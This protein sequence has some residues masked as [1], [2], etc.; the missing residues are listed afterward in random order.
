MSLKR[1]GKAF[2][3]KTNRRVFSLQ[4]EKEVCYNA[5]RSCKNVNNN[6]QGESLCFAINVELR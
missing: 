2:E 3:A 4:G 5:N 6:H 1:G